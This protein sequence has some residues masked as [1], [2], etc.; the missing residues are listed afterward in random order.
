MMKRIDKYGLVFAPTL[1]F[2]G[3]TINLY[4][5]WGIFSNYRQEREIL[6]LLTEIGLPQD[7]TLEQKS[8]L[9][10]NVRDLI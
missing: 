1:L 3:G 7:L 4:Q 8:E 10:T 5:A 6:A 9:L 2:V